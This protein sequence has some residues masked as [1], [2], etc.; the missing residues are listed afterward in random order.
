MP[1][2]LLN[3]VK[4]YLNFP[5]AFHQSRFTNDL[6]KVTS[7]RASAL[8]AAAASLFIGL[9]FVG[10]GTLMDEFEATNGGTDTRLG[11]RSL[12]SD[13]LLLLLLR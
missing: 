8:L 2:V 1:K 12:L 3:F 9:G 7:C 5:L 4:P 6:F 11:G 13:S 10:V